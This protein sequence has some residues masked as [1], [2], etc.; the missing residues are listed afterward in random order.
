MATL[1]E[2]VGS[3]LAHGPGFEFATFLALMPGQEVEG[4]TVRDSLGPLMSLVSSLEGE[5]F[6]QAARSP[7]CDCLNSF[8]RCL[9]S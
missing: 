3:G 2:E 5:N 1:E 6:A 8:L 7:K 4:V 9:T